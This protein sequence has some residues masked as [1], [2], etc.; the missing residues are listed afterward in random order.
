M[1]K[2]NDTDLVVGEIKQLLKTFNL[3]KC[4]VW[5]PIKPVFSGCYYLYENHIYQALNTGIFSEIDTVNFKVIRRYTFN[6]K[7][8]NATKQYELNNL[9][10]DSYCHRYLGEYLRFIRDYKGLNLMSMY[11]CFSNELAFNISFGL[12]YQD[13]IDTV[14]YVDL[15][16]PTDTGDVKVRRDEAD[17]SSPLETVIINN[18]ILDNIAVTETTVGKFRVYAIPV[19][20]FQKYTIC[21]DSDAT[22]ELIADFYN[23]N[24][25]INVGSEDLMARLH[26]YTYHR[27]NTLK[28]NRPIC[29]TQLNELFG[30]IDDETMKQFYLQEQ[31]L[32][33]F[34]KVPASCKSAVVILEGDFTKDTE[35]YFNKFNKP[36]I[37]GM[38]LQYKDDVGRV[39][40]QRDYKT[41]HQLLHINSGVNHPIADKLLEYL[42]GNV[43]TML[44]PIAANISRVQDKL[45]HPVKR[46]NKITKKEETILRKNLT[47]YRGI[48]EEADRQAIYDDACALKLIDDKFDILGYVD[49]DIEGSEIIGDYTDGE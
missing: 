46:W 18:N 11:N 19:K 1:I 23:E 28:F 12:N 31:N 16:D 3:P 30:V 2:Y 8:L 22:V 20:F 36:V 24:K 4:A 29:Y 34:I 15:E 17:A 40:T 39:L 49:K 47:S 5:D 41:K 38:P 44:D 48:W 6:D 27:Y 43:I 37:A 7:I 14:E 32:K 10:Y 21:I 13:A 35:Y 9:I 25:R 45:E 26:L 42:S 33:L